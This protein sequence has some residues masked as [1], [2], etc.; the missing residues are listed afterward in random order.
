MDI[1]GLGDKLADQ[2]V[3]RGLIEDLSDLFGLDVET[4]AGLERMGEKSAANLVAALEKSRETTLPRFLFALGILGIGETMAANV[5]AACRSLDGV[6]ALRLADL[7]EIKA[8]QARRLHEALVADRRLGLDAA[9]IAALPGL[10]WFHQ[11]HAM[12]L[13]ERF[14]DAAAVRAAPPDDLANTPDIKIEGV[15]DV[16]A[17]KLVTFFRQPHNREVIGKLLEAGVRWPAPRAAAAGGE[18]RPL[19]GKTFVLTGTLSAPRDAIKAQLQALGAKVAGSVSGR[20]DYVVAGEEA[21]S[22][23]DKARA[24]GVTVLDEQGLQAL[25]EG[26]G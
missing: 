23:L 18:S 26:R 14:G 13:A 15:G 12:L 11:S 7:V 24:L 19:Q 4:L 8:S 22:K 10:K 16:L 20:T 6:M 3:D 5:A 9:A 25:M 1:E 21:G 17:E 2:L